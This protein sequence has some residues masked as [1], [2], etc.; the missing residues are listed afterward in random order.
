M[1][2][3]LAHAFTADTPASLSAKPGAA[4]YPKLL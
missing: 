4:V 2:A 3:M 1:P